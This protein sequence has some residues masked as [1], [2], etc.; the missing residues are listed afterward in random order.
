MHRKAEPEV[1]VVVE[2][3]AGRDYPVHKPRLDQRYQRGHAEAGRRHGTG[4][5]HPH[6]R[7]VRQHL[8]GEQP[9]RLAQA[10]GVVGEECVVDQVGDRFAAADGRRLNLGSP[11]VTVGF[12]RH[13]HPFPSALSSHGH[14]TPPRF[15]DGL[16]RLRGVVR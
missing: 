1:G 6:R 14:H 10:A 4:K 16:D 7:I 5:T 11:Q 2:I 15:H 3:G 12:L 8:L 9:A 13:P